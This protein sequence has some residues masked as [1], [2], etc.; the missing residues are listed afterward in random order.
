MAMSSDDR[1]SSFD[2]PDQQGD[3]DRYQGGGFWS[4]QDEA[5]ASHDGSGGFWSSP[6]PSRRSGSA[7]PVKLL[8]R[9]AG[10]LA[11][12]FAVVAIIVLHSTTN[13]KL[14]GNESTPTRTATPTPSPDHRGLTRH[15]PARHRPR[16][17][18]AAEPVAAVTL[19]PATPSPPGKV[20]HSHKSPTS[21]PIASKVEVG[22]QVTCLSGKSVEGVWVQADVDAGFAPWQGVNVPGK[23]FGSTSRWWWWL[24][25]GESYSLHVG[26]GGTQANWGVAGHTPVVSG[27]SNSFDC[28]DLPAQVGYGTCYRR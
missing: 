20:R 5:D 24:P 9:L 2:D 13:H 16:R 11:V 23:A 22:G 26:C 25:N 10:V 4:A 12:V 8:A 28:I 1:W 21:R 14:A 19:V 17:H 27:T 18:A 6:E 3:T 15:R 7:G